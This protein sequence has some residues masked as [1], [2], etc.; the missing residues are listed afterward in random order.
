MEAAAA[1]RADLLELEVAQLKRQLLEKD[2]VIKRL[3]A[4]HALDKDV[5]LDTIFTFLGVNE[6]LYI[7]GVCRRWRGR[8]ISIC[9]KARSSADVS[10]TKTLHSATFATVARFE[11]ELDCGLQIRSEEAEK[12]ARVPFFKDLAR[13]RGA[14]WHGTMSKDA[15]YYRDFELLKWLYKSGCIWNTHAIALQLLGMLQKGE[16]RLLM[17]QWLEQ[18]PGS[19]PLGQWHKAVLLFDAGMFSNLK[20]AEYLLA[21]G[22]EWPKSFTAFGWHGAYVY[23]TWPVS[24]AR[25]ALSQ[26]YSWE[27]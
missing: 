9:C 27:G 15:A 3:V 6:Y 5:V 21:Q 10:A 13:V 12:T 26:G 14:A 11:L 23:C 24:S 7:G 25:W 8:Y 4:P 22:A 16:Q 18:L 17:L 1:A 19:P 20:A 2:V